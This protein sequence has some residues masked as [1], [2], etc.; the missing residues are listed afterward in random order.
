MKSLKEVHLL[1][2]LHHPNIIH[3]QHVWLEHIS[4]NGIGP[5]DP[6][7]T[8]FVLMSYANGGSLA[9]WISS[10]SGEKTNESPRSSEIS[11]LKS[12]SQSEKL[13]AAFRKKKTERG[14]TQEKFGI[15]IHLLREEE[16]SSLLQDMTSGLGFLH[17][18]GVLHLDIK[19][20]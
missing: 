18:R 17:D 2:S 9:D 7:P 11:T 12:Q 20:A 5:K 16:I 1:E 4:F 10:R 8:L 14:T 19:P 6:I 3:Y 13:K 15:G